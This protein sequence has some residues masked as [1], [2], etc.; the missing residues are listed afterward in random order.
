MIKCSI[1]KKNIAVIFITKVVNGKQEP[2]GLCMQCAQKQGIAPL[3]QIIQQT[4]LSQSDFENLNNQMLDLFEN[5]DVE[6]LEDI[7][8]TDEESGSNQLLRALNSLPEETTSDMDDKGGKT[9]NYD[10]VKVK[11]K[12]QKKHKF[13]DTY[14][15]NLTDRAEK[16]EID[17]II[18]REHEIERVIQI[19][20]RRAK[21]NP[22]LIGEPGVENSNSRRFGRVLSTNRYQQGFCLTDIFAIWQRLLLVLFRGH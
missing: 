20:N 6:S 2:V 11:S 13:L 5:M 18:G 10:N 17:R 1:C 16:G 8:P 4:G 12:K 14:G 19:L 22:V 21:N 15:T 3:D 9:S 7:F